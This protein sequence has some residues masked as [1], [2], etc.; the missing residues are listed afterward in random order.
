[1]TMPIFARGISTYSDPAC[2]FFVLSTISMI[3]AR[4]FFTASAVP[5]TLTWQGSV[6]WSRASTLKAPLFSRISM[7]VCACFPMTLPKSALGTGTNS[8]T[9][10]SKKMG[11]FSGGDSSLRLE[12]SIPHSPPPSRLPLPCIPQLE[13]PPSCIPQLELPPSSPSAEPGP[14]RGQPGPQGPP[15]CWFGQGHICPPCM[16]PPGPPGIGGH[17][18]PCQPR[19][20]TFCRQSTSLELED[21]DEEDDRRRFFFFFLPFLLSSLPKKASGPE[22]PQP[23]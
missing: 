13:F 20:Q 22:P 1:M 6:D 15:I 10:G 8:S 18:L 4:A 5:A 3:S 17:M 9:A 14:C 23:P 7:I 21:E 11:T 12:D 16:G 19:F 2:L